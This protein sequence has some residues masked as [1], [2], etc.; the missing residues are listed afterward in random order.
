[1]SAI[2]GLVYLDGRPVAASELNLMGTAVAALGPDGGGIWTSGHVGLGQRLMCFTPEDRLERQPVLDVAGQ[3]VLIADARIDNRPELIEELGIS[4]MEAAAMPDSAYILRA[5]E[6]WGTDC[7]CH[8]LGAWVF[9]L[10]DLRAQHVLI[11]RSQMGERSLFYYE[12]PQVFAFA[13]APKGLFA[14]PFVPRQVNQQSVAD[15]L[16]FATPEPGSCFFSGINRLQTG[17][18]MVIQRQGLRSR[19][20]WQMDLARETRFPHDSD[21][22]DAFNA[23]FDRVIADQLRSLTPVGVMMSGGLDSTAVAATAASIL[24]RDGKRLH[25]FTEVPRAGFDEAIIK[26]RY[27]DETPYVEA[28]ARMYDNLDLHLVRTDGQFY[29]DDLDRFFAAAEAPFRNASNLVWI[30]AISEDASVRNARVLLTGMLGNLTISWD[31]RGLVAQLVAARKWRT[32]FHEARALATQ[33]VADSTL[34]ALLGQGLMPHAPAPLWN[35]IQQLR[36]GNTSVFGVGH[37]WRKFSPLDSDFARIHRVEERGLDKGCRFRSRPQRHTRATRSH[38]I[39]RMA[40]QSGDIARGEETLFG[41]QK[42]DP[43]GD[44]RLLEF[45]LSLPEEQFLRDGTSRWLVRRAMAGRVPLEVTA[46][47]QRG[48]QAADW[49]ERLRKADSRIVDELSQFE[50]SQLTRSALDLGRMRALLKSMAKANPRAVRTRTD[51]RSV[52]ELG[53]MTGRFLCW[54]ESRA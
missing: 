11:A 54:M 3:R 6:K 33:G 27:A 15:Y 10:Y 8:L 50:A 16:G 30:D 24:K 22:V 2:F 42:R 49:F 39:L 5:Y 23:L 12:T 25:A 18:S 9:A 53:V 14:L 38:S 37:P 31:G 35:G 43:T 26:G 46:N 19:R 44:L 17:H 34:R 29:L 48:M 28:M 32:A 47:R 41:V 40:D 13:S 4:S 52:L 1:M 21:Y 45:C 7:P 51:Y 20:Y 36:R